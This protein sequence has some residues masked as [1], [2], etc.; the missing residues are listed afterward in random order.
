MLYRF[1]LGLLLCG[2]I[3]SCTNPVSIS[4]NKNVVTAKNI[5]S[6]IT[7]IT[8]DS[9]VAYHLSSYQTLV[10]ASETDKLHKAKLLWTLYQKL[11]NQSKESDACIKDI[12]AL[13]PSLKNK[14]KKLLAQAFAKQ[15]NINAAAGNYHKV[16]V[17]CEKFLFYDTPLTDTVT[18]CNILNE[19]A[20]AY[21]RLGDSKK[22]S[23][24]LLMALQLARNTNNSEIYIDAASDLANSYALQHKYSNARDILT[25]ALRF[26]YLSN[27]DRHWLMMANAQYYESDEE[28]IR[29]LEKVLNRT[30]LPYT[31]FNCC[32]ILKDVY[33]EKSQYTQALTYCFKALTM[34]EQEAREIAKIYLSIGNIYVQ[35]QHKD[36]A[37]KY[38]DI[39]L[40]TITPV[41]IIDK[42]CYPLYE[43]LKPENTIYDLLIAKADLTITENKKDSASL[44]AALHYLSHAKK[45][46]DLLR[47]ELVFDESKFKMG[48][49]LKIVSE[50]L[51]AVYFTLYQTYHDEQYAQQAFMVAENAKAV[52]LQD[53]IEKDLLYNETLDSNYANYIT[54]RRQLSEVEV[55]LMSSENAEQKDSLQK[56]STQLISDLGMYK[57]LS[58]ALTPM[59]DEEITFDNVS[60]YLNDN[61]FC[62]LSYF[63]AHD[64]IYTLFYDPSKNNIQFRANDSSL[65]DSAKTLA[66]LQYQESVYVN[67]KVQFMRLSNSIYSALVKP[68]V[69][70]K[71]LKKPI[72]LFADGVLHNIAF[73]AMLTDANTWNSF[74]VKQQNIVY[75]YSLR[76]LISQQ[77]RKQNNDQQIY[78]SAPFTK[79]GRDQLPQLANSANEVAQIV[80]MYKANVNTDSQATLKHFQQAM[81]KHQYLHIASH[82]SA[83]EIPRLAFYDTSILVNMLYQI[84]M[85]QQVA[86]LN[87]CQSGA[88][89]TIFSEGN[90]SL[91]R[92]FYS[93]GVHNIILSLWNSNDASSAAISQNF[94]RHLLKIN[95]SVE[96]LHATKLDYLTQHTA[97]KQTPYYW[98]GMQHIGDGTVVSTTK[99]LTWWKYLLAAAIL[100]IASFFIFSY[101]RKKQDRDLK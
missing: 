42:H 40:K 29:S 56:R 7:L 91:G 83:D 23:A 87:T 4:T 60:K 71:P 48:E 66:S 21:D 54:L 90:L 39:G 19:L 35:L 12:I 37:N 6:I 55:M 5:D 8:K 62:A 79:Q 72:L 59:N 1:I 94:Y 36:S 31:Q 67:N 101:F 24:N 97:D 38:F 84:P 95:N 26:K 85:N 51:I 30:Q 81:N 47:K 98:A 41:E 2:W 89:A 33:I 11:P 68:F 34:P 32:K 77:Q 25:E 70:N 61:S 18:T 69:S 58:S 64:K 80:A 44:N 20:T 74:L 78:I 53:N 75:A 99:N 15:V 73:D 92:A 13:E 27:D 57:A 93:N 86:Y 65:L 100:S 14:D 82:A 28:K 46:S 17:D 63:I 43:K 45:V 9:N 76:S 16:V 10:N 22:A 52:T 88:G 49:D 50:R 3:F 96:A